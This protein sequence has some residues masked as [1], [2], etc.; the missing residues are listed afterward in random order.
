MG[1]YLDERGNEE[2]FESAR[3]E[4]SSGLSP[5]MRDTGRLRNSS[6]ASPS[7]GRRGMSST[8]DG[9]GKRSNSSDDGT[10]SHVGKKSISCSRDSKCDFT[11]NCGSGGD[12]RKRRVHVNDTAIEFE[13]D[14]NGMEVIH[15]IDSSI[16][17][18]IAS[19]NSR[20][21]SASA[22]ATENSSHNKK[23]R[24]KKNKIAIKNRKRSAKVI[25][26]NKNI[27]NLNFLF[28][29]DS[30]VPTE[31]LNYFNGF[32]P[33]VTATANVVVATT[34]IVNGDKIENTLKINSH[35]EMKTNIANS[36]LSSNRI[37]QKEVNLIRNSNS[38]E[39]T[40]S[41]KNPRN[42][43]VIIDS[44][45]SSSKSY[46]YTN[47]TPND[48]CSKNN[49]KEWES[50]KKV[51]CCVDSDHGS[52]SVLKVTCDI[53]TS[54]REGAFVSHHIVRKE[55]PPNPEESS[56]DRILQIQAKACGG[57]ESKFSNMDDTPGL[58]VSLS[59][60]A[61]DQRYDPGCFERKNKDRRA[62]RMSYPSILKEKCEGDDRVDNF[63]GD[64]LFEYYESQ[65]GESIPSRCAGMKISIND[66]P[67]LTLME[68]C[69]D[70]AASN[71]KLYSC[72]KEL[73]KVPQ[74]P[75]RRRE[76]DDITI[77]VVTFQ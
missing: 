36:E 63:S 14:P 9:K 28:T 4:S 42:H 32:L 31:A 1:K 7:N 75:A 34:E 29:L 8:G 30:H 52:F 44:P 2:V 43:R 33:L 57:L 66:G 51:E 62:K 35:S 64:F 67:A 21:P 41:I 40:P 49:G 20:S 39:G 25:W 46:S 10:S 68:K 65:T 53:G 56:S 54:H 72:G 74:G 61:E 59:N 11:G 48:I 73:R 45:P 26:S 5:G 77:L 6:A 22:S 70:V 3:C 23:E 38:K 71:S 15:A 69:L 58:G 37:P 47:H 12:D 16:S 19:S 13:K 27:E 60:S 24:E 18:S 50:V 17:S 55:G 76:V